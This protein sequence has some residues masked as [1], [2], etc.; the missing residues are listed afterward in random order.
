[1]VP[2]ALLLLVGKG[3]G[4]N[5]WRAC[6]R[7]AQDCGL[8]HDCGCVHHSPGPWALRWVKQDCRTNGYNGSTASFCAWKLDGRDTGDGGQ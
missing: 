2:A 6:Q 7:V 8:C 5:W 1:M 4:K 3:D